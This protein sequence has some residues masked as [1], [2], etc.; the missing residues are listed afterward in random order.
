MIMLTNRIKRLGYIC[1]YVWIFS[2]FFQI[3]FIYVKW[4]RSF[5]E[6]FWYI[7]TENNKT[8]CGN[9]F[10]RSATSLIQ[11]TVAYSDWV[12]LNSANRME[13]TIQ[14]LHILEW[15]LIFLTI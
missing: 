4:R 1:T 10:K 7:F 2:D 6:S 3:S 14:N 15:V 9:A 11:F 8:G 12:H 5:V 13:L